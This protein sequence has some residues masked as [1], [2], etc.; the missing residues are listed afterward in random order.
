MNESTISDKKNKRQ[1]G[2]ASLV[3][4]SKKVCNS[5]LKNEYTYSDAEAVR[6]LGLDS[7]LIARLIEDY[8]QQIMRAIVSFE[9]LLYELQSAKDAKKE[10]DYTEFRDL[11]HKNLGVA[12]NLRIKDAE[13]LLEELMKKDDLEYLFSCTEALYACTI[14][15]NPECAYDALALIEVKS[16]F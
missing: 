8:I 4:R 2:I 7:E 1:K 12:R 5:F 13:M 11:A 9:E 6:E 14:V 15:L 3:A 16:S 10:L